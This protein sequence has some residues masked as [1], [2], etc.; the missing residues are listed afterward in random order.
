MQGWSLVQWSPP[1]SPSPPASP[2]SRGGFRTFWPPALM[3][4]TGF[5][6]SMH[7]DPRNHKYLPHAAGVA[8]NIRAIQ[9][10]T[11]APC[12]QLSHSSL[13]CCVRHPAPRLRGHNA[14]VAQ[15]R[16]VAKAARSVAPRVRKISCSCHACPMSGRHRPRNGHMQGYTHRMSP[17]STL[18]RLLPA[19]SMHLAC[20]YISCSE[21][22]CVWRRLLAL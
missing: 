21:P 10:V 22:F 12:A 14:K 3:T 19:P 8:Q 6:T 11:S 16:S 15:Q 18:Q 7:R 2:H 17:C 20:Y 5:H 4:A 13:T 1:Y 9:C